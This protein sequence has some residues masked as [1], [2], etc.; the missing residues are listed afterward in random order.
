LAERNARVT[1]I[2]IDQHRV[3]ISNDLCHLLD[4]DNLTFIHG[5]MDNVESPPNTYDLIFSYGALPLSPFISTL[6][7]LHQILTPGG[8][9]YFSA[10]GLGHMINNILSPRNT[11]TDFCPREWAISAIDST[12]KYLYSG[13]FSQSSPRDS[14]FIPKSMAYKVLDDC[15]FCNIRIFPEGSYTCDPD[16]PTMSFAPIQYNNQY[17]AVYEVICSK[18]L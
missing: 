10:Y 13:K 2:D 18:P 17:E 4:L 3:S 7:S 14:L 11:T 8:T 12:L 6:Q 15:G 9:L 5:K 1:G 16:I